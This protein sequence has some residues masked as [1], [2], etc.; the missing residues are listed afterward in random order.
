MSARARDPDAP[1]DVTHINLAR[2]YRGGERQTELL[3]RALDRRG[4]AQA[5]VAREGEPLA[6]RLGDLSGVAI[7]PSSASPLAAARA[8]GR[9]ALIHVHE[10]R[11]LRAAWLN[12]LIGSRPYVVTRRVEKG[13]KTH[14]LNRRMYRDSAGVVALSDAIAAAVHR[15][16]AG[17]SIEIVPSAHGALASDPAR[18]AALRKR[19]GGDFVVGHVGALDDSHKGQSLII[20]AAAGLAGTHPGMRFVLVGDGPDGARL[21]E[22]ARGLGLVR[23]AG[24]VENVGDYLAAFDVFVFP[25]RHEGLGSILLDALHFGLPIVATRVGGIPEVVDDGINGVL[26]AAGDAD[27]IGRALA[28]LAG[29]SDEVARIAAANR[30]KAAAFSAE[31]MADRYEAIYRSVLRQQ[32]RGVT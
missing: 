28:G 1:I 29:A 11:S 26:V 15:L 31:V 18:V 4:W 3:V 5:L 21:R 6:R 8:I 30:E 16:D 9:P 22:S 24:Q 27:A 13:P 10:G 19:W 2:G 20:E 17:L 32:N 25:S 12:A 23:F 14:W 7:R